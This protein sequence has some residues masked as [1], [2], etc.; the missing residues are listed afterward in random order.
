[1]KLRNTLNKVLKDEKTLVLLEQG[2]FSV[3]S[4]ASTAIFARVLGLEQF[5]L[6]AGIVLLSHFLLSICS[7]FVIMPMQVG[8]AKF[9]DKD[10]Y[11][12]F[13]LLLQLLLITALCSLLFF[14]SKVP[15]ITGLEDILQNRLIYGFIAFT[16]L[17]DFFR[18]YFLASSQILKSLI[19]T[20]VMA[21]VQFGGILI[22]YSHSTWSID[23][24]LII[25]ASASG[26]SAIS[27]HCIKDFKLTWKLNS[28]Y[29]H[30][31]KKEGKFLFMSSLLQWWGSNLFVVASGLIIGVQALG[32]FRLVQSM[33]GVLN[34]LLQ[35]FENYVLPKAAMVAKESSQ[36]AL[37]FVRATL[38][39][40]AL[41]FAVVLLPLFV[42]SKEA[43]VLFGGGEFVDYHLIVKGMVVLYVFIF[44]G[45][46]AR[47]PIRIFSLNK[48]FFFG[49]LL[50]FIFS[51]LTFQFMLK[52]F[53][54]SGAIAGLIVNQILMFSYWKF[55]LRKKLN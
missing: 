49:Y 53:G 11:P 8:L 50:S 35:T 16:L 21:V 27:A 54:V 46:S 51:A 22:A 24:A 23:V 14:I 39:K 34:L 33:F 15:M 40:S 2:V 29:F 44:I 52:G 28:T 45:Y 1:M 10:R 41:P 4:F 26:L 48:A 19:S 9:M 31:H 42:F 37:A 20:S 43:I 18:K 38:M 32:A 7:A 25:V 5:G 47:L 30:Y 13:A 17:F 55:R 6:Y 12:S 36:Q 3:N